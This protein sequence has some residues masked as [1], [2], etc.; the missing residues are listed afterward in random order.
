MT[1]HD[2]PWGRLSRIVAAMPLLCLLLFAVMAQAQ[3]FTVLHKFTNGLDGAHPY[4]GLTIDRAGNLYGTAEYGGSQANDCHIVSGCGTV[5]ELVHQGAGFIFRPLYQFQGFPSGDGANPQGR[6]IVGPDGALYGTTAYGGEDGSCGDEEPGCG[7]VFKLT[8]PPTF[9]KSFT[10]NWEETQLYNFTGT[11]DGAGPS[12]EIAFD[13][14][15][16]LYGTTYDGASEFGGTVYE[17]TPAH[18]T[19]TLSTLAGFESGTNPYGGVQL[20]RA[21]NVYGTTELF[22]TAFQLLPSGSGWTLNNLY[23]FSYNGGGWDLAAGLI[24]GPGGNLYGGTA[25]GSP[26]PVIFEL[27]PSNGGWT[28]NPFY[29]FSST[30]LSANLVMDSTGNLYGTTL[31][32]SEEQIYG[33]VFKLTP[34]DGGWIYTDLHDFTNGSDGALPYSSIVIDSAGNLYG[35]ASS[36]GGDRCPPSGTGCGVVWEI[37]P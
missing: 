16:N 3:T 19:W 32:D 6:V 13:S 30:G 20:D 18:G 8:P 28:Y 36:G 25:A 15:G 33:S 34:S 9:C 22:G 7:T 31:G 37:T 21:G 17:L 27:S 35:T 12:G 2:Q 5:F 11:G 1:Y 29:T 4:T 14:A 10:C 23:E 26:S 24:V